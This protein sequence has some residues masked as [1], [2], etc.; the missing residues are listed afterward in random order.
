MEQFLRGEGATIVYV[1]ERQAS[2]TGG[3]VPLWLA[4]STFN[5]SQAGYFAFSAATYFT[6]LNIA[7][8]PG[9]LRRVGLAAF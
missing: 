3:V 9:G 8:E 4:P 5:V 2:G 1:V 7:I 6:V